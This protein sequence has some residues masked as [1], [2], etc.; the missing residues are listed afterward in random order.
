MARQ[1][2]ATY[3]KLEDVITSSIY[4]EVTRFILHEVEE[5]V[6]VHCGRILSRLQKYF[7]H[8]FKQAIREG[9]NFYL[10]HLLID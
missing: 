7:Q 3:F 1:L 2:L 10:E 4:L 6:Q 5:G 8:L 9:I